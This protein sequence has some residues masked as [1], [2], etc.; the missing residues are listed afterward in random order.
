MR[1][2]VI[3][4]GVNSN[5]INGL[6]INE[7]PPITKPEMRNIR[8]EIDGRDGDITTNLGYSAYD[9]TITIGLF[10][11]GYDINDIVAF[12]NGEGTIVFS[13]EQDKYYNFK[14]LNQIDYESLQKFRT[15]SITFHCQPFKYPLSET[16]LEIEYGYIEQE[17]ETLTLNN[18]GNA[19]MELDL[20]GNTSQSGTPTPTS[21]IPVSV[22]SGDNDI[23]VCGKN[24]LDN[25]SFTASTTNI[26]TIVDGVI[27]TKALNNWN[28][29]TV[30]INKIH[31]KPNTNYYCTAKVKKVS[32]ASGN[33]SI[34]Y[35]GLLNDGV[36]NTNQ[37]RITRPVLTTDYQTFCWKITTTKD[38][39]VG[40][41][42]NFQ[43]F[44]DISNLV[45]SIKDIMF[46]QVQDDT[47]EPYQ[48][49]T[50][51]V[52]LP[53]ENIN[54]TPYKDGTS[55]TTNGITFSVNDKGE[56]IANGTASAGTYFYFHTQDTS[57]YL[58]IPKG[59]YYLSGGINANSKIILRLYQ[60]TTYVA[61]FT[62]SGSG[63]SIDTSSYTYNRTL[64]F[65]EVANGT[66]LNNATFKPMLEKGSK[67]NSF[68]PY[69]TTPIEL[70]KIGTYQ[71]YFT[72]NSD[73]QWCKY[74]AIGKVVLDGSET[75]T[76]QQ[77]NISYGY[78]TV[79]T[80][81]ITPA[82]A[83]EM[84]ISLCNYYPVK[85]PG[86]N[87]NTASGDKNYCINNSNNY[88]RFS[89]GETTNQLAQFKTWLGTNKPVVYYA[90]L[91]PYL[92]LI[93]DNN[94]IEQLDNLENA[95]SYEG[96]TNI[97]QGNNDKAFII[98]AKAIEDGTNEV[99][100]NNIGNVY[101]KPLLALEGNGNV[102]IYLDNTQILRANIED[103]MN[104]DIAQLE[105]YNP[106][107]MTLLNRQ[108]IGNYNSMTLQPGNNTIRIDGSLDKATITNYTRWL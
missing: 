90:L 11:T 96:T 13:N 68:T 74:N 21:P 92:S 100:V 40:I 54:F 86:Q 99:V 52:D 1:N 69:G 34:N 12:F 5:T 48:S 24:M 22:V 60:D 77:M 61:S 18:T 56:V 55:K 10:G 101:S 53:V 41:K 71:D 28:V 64:L 98:S 14:I 35:I 67:Q 4:N 81:M 94:L 9:K 17:G 43:M 25:S 57:P 91:T 73:G 2:F 95:M 8:E 82:T 97:G 26:D 33:E 72:K 70:C 58:N 46:S 108:V 102:D 59:T 83:G 51:E 89:N 62:D 87:W 84:P 104:I 47:Y 63:V 39:F 107:T 19:L 20:K 7:L 6:G 106:D 49:Q 93:E 29:A 79:I 44:N 30:N 45:L 15:A 66:T 3:I 42:M 76:S 80:N 85:T 75:W 23:V 36:D 27:T 78:Q 37:A 50:Y 88:V 103:K 105:A 65:I 16:P 38:N 32:G 31:L